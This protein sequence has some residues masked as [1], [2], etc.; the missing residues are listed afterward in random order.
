MTIASRVKSCSKSLLP[1]SARKCRTAAI[2]PRPWRSWAGPWLTCSGGPQN[3]GPN[4]SKPE[5]D[6]RPRQAGDTNLLPTAKNHHEDRK[7]GRTRLVAKAT[8]ESWKPRKQAG[9]SALKARDHFRPGRKP[10]LTGPRGEGHAPFR[11][12]CGIPCLPWPAMARR[13]GGPTRRTT[14]RPFSASSPALCI[15]AFPEILEEPPFSAHEG[16]LG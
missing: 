9:T 15:P 4:W 10:P 1:P 6:S 13:V 7:T 12:L 2:G 5:S 8:E 11:V 16:L 3:C 14:Q